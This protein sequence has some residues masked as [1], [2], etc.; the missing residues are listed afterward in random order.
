[1]ILER[2]EVEAELLGQHR[3]LD[4]DLRRRVRRGDEGA[5]A[6][7]VAVVGH[8]SSLPHRAEGTMPAR[9]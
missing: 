1:M 7:V 5:E 9:G 8:A 4:R 2:D 6:E 3:Q